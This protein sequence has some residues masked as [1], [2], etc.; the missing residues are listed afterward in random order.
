MKNIYILVL[1]TIQ[2]SCI[3]IVLMIYLFNK[4]PTIELAVKWLII[5]FII[6]IIFKKVVKTKNEMK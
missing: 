3:G 2:N 5:G 6:T 4:M 1:E